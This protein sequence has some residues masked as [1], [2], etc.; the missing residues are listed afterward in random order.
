[1][2]CF[3]IPNNDI[4]HSSNF[5]SK[6]KMS[7]TF[8]RFFVSILLA[9]LTHSELFP[10]FHFCVYCGTKI[11]HGW[12]GINSH[13]NMCWVSIQDDMLVINSFRM[14][15]FQKHELFQCIK[16]FVT[17]HFNVR[18]ELKLSWSF[19]HFYTSSVSMS[20]WMISF[21]VNEENEWILVISRNGNSL[22]YDLS[23]SQIYN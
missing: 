14:K 6:C 22:I 15:G 10:Y 13:N 18:S 16:W 2:R 8:Y 3:L 23:F 19:F 4:I 5:G 17:F 21:V 11:G 12:H 20:R 7:L 9:S 1:M